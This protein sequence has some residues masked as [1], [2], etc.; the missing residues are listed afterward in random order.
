M[1][2]VCITL[3]GLT[4]AQAADLVRMAINEWARARDGDY[5]ETR[6]AH[7]DADFR[8]RRAARLDTEL[9]ALSEMSID[10]QEA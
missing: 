9:A 10:A 7:M 5:V 4:P 8:A 2:T 3:P 6:Y 1:A